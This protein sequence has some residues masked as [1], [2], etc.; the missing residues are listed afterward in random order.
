[1]KKTAK[2]LWSA[3]LVLTMLLL[4]AV[5]A[6]KQYLRENVVRM[7]IRANS[8]SVSDQQ[9]KLAVRDALLEYLTETD[10]NVSNA[11]EAKAFLQ[12]NLG[13]L[14]NRANSVLADNNSQHCAKVSLREE[15]FPT[16]EYEEFSLPAGVYDA[17]VVEIGNA[18][19]K[20]WWCVVF[21]S[22]CLQ[23]FCTAAA[24]V[25]MEQGLQNTLSGNNGYE[26][27]FFLLECIGKIENFFHN[28]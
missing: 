25:D 27:R 13:E 10:E 19:G 17:L 11:G 20:N 18:E 22:L 5:L 12:E 28:S 23:D 15:A 2:I 1:M 9:E 4:G 26:V 7:H 21:P 6:D 16:R 14:E 24:A 8:D 3:V